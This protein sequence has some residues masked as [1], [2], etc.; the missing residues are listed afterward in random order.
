MG[1]LLKE[2]D[3]I[4]DC[5]LSSPALRARMTAERLGLMAND[6]GL[7]IDDRLYE[8]GLA[9]LYQVIDGLEEGLKHVALIGH[10]PDFTRL[11][12][13]LADET[14]QNL[15]TCGV[16]SIVFEVD[17]WRHILAGSGRLTHYDYPKRH[18]EES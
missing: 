7:L 5:I 10:N 1:R 16:A 9:G 6:R 15:P 18:V 3:L 2:K 4:P 8:H 17:S 14:L 12:N 13:E 11:L